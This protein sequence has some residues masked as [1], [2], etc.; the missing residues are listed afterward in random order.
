V[1]PP[2]QNVEPGVPLPDKIAAA[3]ARFRE[4]IPVNFDSAYVHSCSKINPENDSNG[5]LARN[6][7]SRSRRTWKHSL[8]SRAVRKLVIAQGTARPPFLLQQPSDRGAADLKAAGERGRPASDLTLGM[9]S[10]FIKTSQRAWCHPSRPNNAL[11]IPKWL[12]G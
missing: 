6:S 8:A 3:L 11:H 1:A 5:I 7:V 2:N 4:A 12:K 10:L 9:R